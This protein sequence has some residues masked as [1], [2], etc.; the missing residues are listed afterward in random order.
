MESLELAPSEKLLIDMAELSRL[1]TISIRTLRR[2]DA[3]REIP[4]RVAVRRW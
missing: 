2:M 3:S 4:G 1:T